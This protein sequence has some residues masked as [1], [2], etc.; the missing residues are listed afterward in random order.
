MDER[1]EKLKKLLDSLRTTNSMMGESGDQQNLLSKTLSSH[2]RR[3]A[4][5]EGPPIHISLE[6]YEKMKG[7]QN[8]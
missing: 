6:E 7:D 1:K 5:M 8:E 4:E 3:F 2:W